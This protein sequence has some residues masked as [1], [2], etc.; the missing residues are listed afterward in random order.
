MMSKSAVHG[1]VCFQRFNSL[2]VSRFFTSAFSIPKARGSKHRPQARCGLLSSRASGIRLSLLS[3]RPFFCWHDRRPMSIGR[4][5]ESVSC[6]LEVVCTLLWDE[7]IADL[8][9]GLPEFV[10][11][12]HGH[13]A[14]MGL[15][16]GEG[17][18]DG[19]EVGAVGRQEQEPGASLA[20]GLFGGRAFVGGQIVQ[21][22]DVAFFAALVRAGCA[23]RC[24]R[25]PGPSARR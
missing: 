13:G 22:D 5:F 11:G 12:A 15:E 20:N 14:E 23:R 21:N 16:F 8:P 10:D 24:R 2:F 18:F 19:I 9:D 7:E 3:G 6:G 4:S 17:H 25:S 1:I